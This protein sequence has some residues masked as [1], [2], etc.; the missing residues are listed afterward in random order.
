MEAQT[1]EV[2]LGIRITLWI[3]VALLGFIAGMILARRG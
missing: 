2:L 1:L 3:I